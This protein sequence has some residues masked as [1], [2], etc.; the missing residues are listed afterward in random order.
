MSLKKKN[1]IK[2][3]CF[4]LLDY[5]CD[6]TLVFDPQG[7]LQ[8]PPPF[9]NIVYTEG[10]GLSFLMANTL[11]NLQGFCILTEAWLQP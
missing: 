8:W 4:Q 5:V 6:F 1:E 11:R 9:S 2:A 7:L 3:E 10:I